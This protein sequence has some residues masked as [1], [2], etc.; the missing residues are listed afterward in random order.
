MN[1]CAFI[2]LLAATLTGCRSNRHVIESATTVADSLA[3]SAEQLV[4][5]KTDSVVHLR[6]LV[7]DTLYIEAALPTETVRVRAVNGR[8][9]DRRQEERQQVA[10]FNRLDSVAFHA[11]ESH[12]SA[13]HTATTKVYNPPSGALILGLLVSIALILLF[14]RSRF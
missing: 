10:V 12:D 2:L 8:V 1:R 11:A 14:I 13:E 7:F 5:V 6:E 3:T 9:S 4:V